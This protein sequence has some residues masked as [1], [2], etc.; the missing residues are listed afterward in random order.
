[1]ETN[2]YKISDEP[3]PGF[4]SSIAVSPIWPFIAVMFGGAWLSWSWFVINGVAVGS[5][6]L[7]REITW[8]ISGIVGSLGLVFVILFAFSSGI[9]PK[10]LVKYAML[11]VVVWKLGVAYKLYTL[12][13]HTI[14]LYEYYGGKLRNGI[15]VVIAALFFTPILLSN[16]PEFLQI[17]LK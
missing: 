7:R 16:S 10:E 4:L 9:L 5:P 1:M 8:V 3:A 17:A 2:Y 13:S 15:I 11:F 6:T 14:E 12:Q